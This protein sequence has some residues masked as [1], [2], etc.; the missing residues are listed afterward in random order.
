[1]KFAVIGYPNE[2]YLAASYCQAITNLG[3]EHILVDIN[4]MD[5]NYAR[6][7]AVGRK[8]HQFLAVSAW[9]RKA[10][11]DLAITINNYRPD[12][13]IV[14]GNMRVNVGAL[15]FLKVAL[16]CKIVWVWPDTL[17]NIE[18]WLLQA[19]GMIDV[20]ASYSN[21]SL[22]VLNEMGFRNAKWVPLAADLQLHHYPLTLDDAKFACDLSFVGGW[23][24][25]REQALLDIIEAF[26]NLNV[27]IFGPLEIWKRQCKNKKVLARVAGDS[28]F[29]K[30]FSA[31]VAA[32]RINLNVIDDTNYPS[33]NM[34]FFELSAAG[35]LQLVSAC[36]EMEATY[37]D[38][39]TMLYFNNK[40][41]MLQKIAW[42][43]SHLAEAQQM[44]ETAQKL[45]AQAH[46]YECRVQTIID[47]F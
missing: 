11:R 13:I 23:R 32:S 26:P 44:R 5:T 35:G 47:N 24:P 34:R 4:A 6:L 21:Q 39:K 28:L 10:N 37:I 18:P 7:G 3:H 17:L 42:A 9:T 40:T 8:L 12:A 41:E 2:A 15:A 1:M 20:F 46:T 38:K 29:G 16:K 14:V 36:P 43:M 31:Q 30:D 22:T 45:T 33:A 19:A 25:E 27:K